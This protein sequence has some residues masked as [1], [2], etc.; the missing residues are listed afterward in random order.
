[1]GWPLK[2]AHITKR[3]F[4]GYYTMQYLKTLHGAVQEISKGSPTFGTL[5]IF[6]HINVGFFLKYNDITNYLD[7]MSLFIWNW[8]VVDCIK[9]A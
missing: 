8:Y 2:I 9:I 3:V 6:I 5:C 7:P 1:M 4:L